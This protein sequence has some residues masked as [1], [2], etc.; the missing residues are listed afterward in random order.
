MNTLN[1]KVEDLSKELVTD[2]LRC[3]A[4][5]MAEPKFSCLEQLTNSHVQKI[6][7]E[8]LMFFQ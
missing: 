7:W 6:P 2:Y 4:M 5:S 1:F 3:L 8:N